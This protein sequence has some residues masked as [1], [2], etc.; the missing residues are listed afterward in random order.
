MRRGRCPLAPASVC[1]GLLG[2][3]THAATGA[4][5][6]EDCA[7]PTSAPVLSVGSVGCQLVHSSFLGGDDPVSYYVPPACDP[8]LARHCPVLYLLHGFGGDYHS[9][10]GTAASPSGWVQ[11]LSAGPPVDPRSVPDPWDYGPSTWV[12]KP[13]LDLVLVAP[14]GRTLPGGYGP[15]PDLDSFWTD[16]NPR[17][18]AGGDSPKYQTPPPRFSSFLTGELLPYVEAHFPTSGGRAWRALAGTSLGGYGSYKNGLQHPDVW[19]SMGSVSGAHTFLF[20]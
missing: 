11:A 5:A 3:P 1:G 17:Y 13:S 16:W 9:M 18:A 19:S 7:A 2:R 12:P 20:A 14:H 15:A 6:F 4:T 8:A 10:L